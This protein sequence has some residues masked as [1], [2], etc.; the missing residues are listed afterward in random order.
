M[1]R[2]KWGTQALIQRKIK[3]GRYKTL[4][5]RKNGGDHKDKSKEEGL[6]I[7]G[8]NSGSVLARLEKP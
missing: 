8:K 6:G 7:G 5:K 4:N 2:K 3:G 1:E